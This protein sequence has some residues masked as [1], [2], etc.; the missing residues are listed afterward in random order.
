MIHNAPTV[1]LIEDDASIA[2][3]LIF[4]L[5][6]EGFHVLHAGDGLQGKALA[7]TAK[8][9]VVLLDIM[10][11][12]LS[13][14]EVCELIRRES[15]VPIVMLTA[16]GQELD[17]VRG[18]QGGAD[19]YIVKPF[20]FQE[21]V[22][23]IQAILRRRQLD[24]GDAL[25]SGDRDRIAITSIVIDR[26]AREVWRKKKKLELSWREFELLWLLMEHVGKALSRHEILDRIWGEDWVG[27]PK[28]LDVYIR[29]LREKIE[30]N[31]SAPEYIQTVRGYGYRF[32]DPQTPENERSRQ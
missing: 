30:K 25:P 27:D 10:L 32:T 24:R 26:V 31:P 29:W 15:V 5:R 14:L 20:S 9:D 23:R 3:P 17:R 2:E 19:D 22:A 13:G 21:L 12:K 28:T 16:K 11:P 18:L 8:P 4:G 1:L 7:L 6:R